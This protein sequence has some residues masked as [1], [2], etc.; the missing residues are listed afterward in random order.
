MIKNTRNH[1]CSPFSRQFPS[2]LK[3]MGFCFLKDPFKEDSRLLRPTHP[4]PA[5]ELGSF[6]LVNLNPFLLKFMLIAFI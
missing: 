3:L 4:R 6:P 1:L 2:H 5:R